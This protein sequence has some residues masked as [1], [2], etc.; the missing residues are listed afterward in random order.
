MW[1]LALKYKLNW[2]QGATT[3]PSFSLCSS[4]LNS[5]RSSI[6]TRDDEATG[7][8][9]RSDPLVVLPCNG[10][11]HNSPKMSEAIPACHPSVLNAV[12]RYS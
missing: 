1:Q 6:K 8:S 2:L 11:G 9:R 5:S 10:L 3:F 4:S 12:G 7:N